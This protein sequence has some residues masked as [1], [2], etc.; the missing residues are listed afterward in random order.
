MNNV[1]FDNYKLLFIMIPLVIIVTIPFVM[2]LKKKSLRWYNLCSLFVHFII[3]VLLTLSLAN[4]KT[5]KTET[6]TSIYIVADVSNTTHT[7]IEEMDEYISEFSS[8]LSASSELGVV[9][10]GKD[11]QELVQL[12]NDIISLKESTVDKSATNIEQAMQFTMGLFEESM[13]KRIVLLTDGKENEGEVLSLKERLNSSEIRV[14]AVYFDSIPTNNFEV[15]LDGVNGSPSSFVNSGAAMTLSIQSSYDTAIEVTIKEDDTVFYYGNHAV[16]KGNNEINVLT[17]TS[18][19]QTHIYE[20]SIYEKNDEVKEN[21]SCYFIQKINE[22]CKVA[23]ISSSRKDAIAIK[24]MI[25]GSVDATDIATYDGDF[26]TNIEGYIEYDEIILSNVDLNA[27]ENKTE[28]AIT[29]NTLVTKYGKSLI[30]FGG[31]NTYLD[32][33]FLSSEIKNMLP[34]DL[35]PS[36]TKRQT[37]VILVIDNSGSMD[38]ERLQMAIAGAKGCLDILSDQDYV[39][40]ITFESNTRVVQPL[41]SVA[42]KDSISR[43]IDS[44]RSGDGTMMTPG[45]IEA[46]EEMQSVKSEITN[47]Y[48]ILISDGSPSDTGQEEVVSQMALE[49]I[50]VSTIAIGRQNN[51]SLLSDLASIGNGNYYQINGASQ[52]PNVILGEVSDMIMDSVIEKESVV[53][54]DMQ[55]DPVLEDVTL[56]DYVYGFNYSKAKYGTTTVLSTT[57][58]L[59]TGET[60]N[61]VPLYAYWDYGKGRV[62]SFM[63]EINERKENGTTIDWTN[64]FFKSDQGI[65]LMNN[66]INVNMPTTHYD[67]PM[68]V[69]VTNKGKTSVVEVGLPKLI[70]GVEVSATVK[71]PNG[72][73]QQQ[74]LILNNDKYVYEFETENPGIYT[75]HI[76][77]YN[78]RTN[79]REFYYDGYFSY[80]YSSEYNQFTPSNNIVLY[81]LVNGLVIQNNSVD[82]IVNITQEDV[83]YS[84]YYIE[85]L[86]IAAVILFII[87]V[88]IRKIRLRDIK[89]LFNKT[90][91]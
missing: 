57:Y 55:K 73:K 41:A 28:F 59:E 25:S 19:A 37:A 29:L 30:T 75:I 17:N 82:E 90:V 76:D 88:I 49:G 56:L 27:I 74:L 81:N 6:K 84:K 67:N 9:A 21:N 10:I 35:S 23:I 3:C 40:V 72:E 71:S 53:N 60:I 52:L 77:Y 87:D 91:K 38:G 43:R 2:V 62:V 16:K 48:V 66:I 24:N 42:F 58:T 83:V 12:G 61:E 20:V 78:P 47:R 79:S 18:V 86:L 80:S 65:K 31:N 15:Q 32:G 22:K 33:G 36:D 69:N 1:M 13:K 7:V 26:K 63:S 14:D 5:T 70:R 85:D 46:F 8:K 68:I 34:V 11:S 45:L 4:I 51:G 89:N 39:G 44:I 64:S 54:I 50:N